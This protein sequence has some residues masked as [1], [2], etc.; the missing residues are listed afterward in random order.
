MKPLSTLIVASIAATLLQIAAL[1]QSSFNWNI[2]NGVWDTSSLNWSSNG[3]SVA[4]APGNNAFFD[5]TSAATT[6]SVGGA[7]TA[8]AVSVGNGGNNAD[9]TFTTNGTSGGSLTA[10]S[11]IVQGSAG[12]NGPGGPTILTNLPLTIT[13]NLGVGRWGLVIGGTSTVNVG[14]QIGGNIAG[15]S[16][17]DWGL[18]TIQNS[19]VVT[20]TGGVNGNTEAWA[21]TLNG[22]TLITPSIQTSDRE[23]SGTAR[24]T[25]NGGTV[26]ATQDNPNFVTVG[27]NFQNTDSAL[28]GDGGA[29]INTAGYNIGIPVN[30][31]S[32]GGT[33]GGLTKNGAGTLTLGGN[34]TYT[35]LTI[36]SNGTLQVD[37]AIGAGAVAVQSGGA[38]SGAG[39]ING[40]VTVNAGGTLEAGDPSGPGA[41]AIENSLTLNTGSATTLRLNESATTNDSVVG[42]S[43]LTYGGT[44]T[45]T[46][47]GG[48]LVA[49]DSFQ[50]FN[51][52]TY[53]G[54]FGATRL[55]AL[56]S[57]LAWNWS[58]TT[59]S[60]AVAAKPAI[61]SFNTLANG[62]FSLGFAGGSGA[63]YTI[64]TS[65]NAAMPLSNWTVLANATN[66][67]SGFF[68][69]TDTTATNRGWSFYETRS[70]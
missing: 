37:G 50:L 17:A 33:D 26:M 45:V 53:S 65:T 4:W 29:I 35:G 46:S 10:S 27:A 14:G 43:T 66:N 28:V 9:Y 25:F 69:F 47:L 40:P 18:L 67:G 30:L 55:P 21:M 3:V 61:T 59:G 20:A 2:G 34:N 32:A 11:F 68:Q 8:A 1:A 36:V 23:A 31:A 58:P 44:L 52:T 56:T 64:V 70:P 54:N 6:I 12:N 51:A 16:S 15:V 22:G 57:S 60:L 39:T 19:A 49:G 41:L 5:N 62:S 38:L 13:G 7:Q 42:I 63:T 24:L 48:T